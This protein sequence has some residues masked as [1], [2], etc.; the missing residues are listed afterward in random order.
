[1]ERTNETYGNCKWRRC[2]INGVGLVVFQLLPEKNVWEQR[3]GDLF[4]TSF[5]LTLP[6]P[7]PASQEQ[8][9]PAMPVPISLR[10]I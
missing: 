9:P 1:M 3:A 4:S 2:K 10:T 8:L 5:F 7:G 6:E